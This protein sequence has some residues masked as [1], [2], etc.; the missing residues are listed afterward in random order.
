MGLID[1]GDQQQQKGGE[2]C[3][4]LGAPNREVYWTQHIFRPMQMKYNPPT[5]AYRHELFPPLFIYK[6]GPN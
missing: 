4:Y 1:Q 2:H 6:K 5:D 3:F